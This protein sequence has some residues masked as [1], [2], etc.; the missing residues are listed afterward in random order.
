MLKTKPKR[1][2]PPSVKKN[3]QWVCLQYEIKKCDVASLSRQRRRAE[4]G[5]VMAWLVVHNY[6]GTLTELAKRFNRGLS[7][8]S[9]AAL[10]IESK[11]NELKSFNRALAILITQLKR[12]DLYPAT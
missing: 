12:S 10:K 2:K 6:I 4:V 7:A 3:V 9:M 8:L 1:P 5:S 11:R